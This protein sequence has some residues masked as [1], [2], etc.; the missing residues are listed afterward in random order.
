MSS[1]RCGLLR[2]PLIAG[3]IVAAAILHVGHARRGELDQLGLAVDG[4]HGV[5]RAAG[6]AQ[7]DVGERLL[8]AAAADDDGE[9][10]V[11]RIAAKATFTTSN[12]FTMQTV[13]LHADPLKSHIRPHDNDRDPDRRLRIGR[14]TRDPGAPV[15]TATTSRGEP[16]SRPPHAS[17]TGCSGH[18]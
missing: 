4:L 1:S 7:A 12:W 14:A 10:I 5:A 9:V 13:R 17:T 11:T 8:V 15:L 6:P 18:R 3:L 16:A 2:W